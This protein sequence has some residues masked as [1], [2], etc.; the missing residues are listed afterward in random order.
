M[1]KHN[2]VY[3]SWRHLFSTVS[4]A[5]AIAA[6]AQAPD[7][8]PRGGGAGG[9]GGGRGFGRGRGGG[10]WSSYVLGSTWAN[11][12]AAQQELQAKGVL[13]TL[14]Q[15]MAIEE[16]NSSLTD[17]NQAVTTAREAFVAATFASPPDADD[18]TARAEALSRAELALANARA[19]A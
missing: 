2:F 13:L 4:L 7:L 16:M 9:D 1:Y 15:R 12:W 10:G 14:Y 6:N 5:F 8:A 17:L 11:A 18:A 3:R 19:E